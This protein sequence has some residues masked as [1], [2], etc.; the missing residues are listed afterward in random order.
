MALSDDLPEYHFN[1]GATK[2]DSNNAYWLS[3]FADSVYLDKEEN[4]EILRDLG[5]ETLAWHSSG[6]TQALVASN[7]ETIIIAFR[8]TEPTDFNDIAAD[9]KAAQIDW[10][11]GKV[12]TGFL[13]AIDEV[14]KLVIGSVAE[15]RNNEQT[16]WVTGHSLGGAL[17]VL[18]ATDLKEN[19]I[20]VNGVYT[21]GQPRLGN[22]VFCELYNKMLGTK[23]FRFANVDDIVPDLP[24]KS[25]K[26]GDAELSY[27]DVGTPIWVTGDS[28][29]AQQ[30]IPADSAIN[31]ALSAAKAPGAHSSLGYRDTL[32]AKLNF[33]PFTAS[34]KEIQEATI[35]SVDDL[36]EETL[37]LLKGAGIDV[38]ELA[39]AAQNTKEAVTD[40]V[41]KASKW[42]KNLFGK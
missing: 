41:D 19:D 9:L 40:A 10:L 20:D 15:Q 39:E 22:H 24:P 6:G 12:H 35:S 5:L 32:L 14:D 27:H 23:T 36:D 1:S 37:E 29:L 28:E 42:T 18:C 3:F 11:G 7:A 16:V 21:F 13:G 26:L 30:Y 25:L 4:E 31:K 34:V 8:G 17:A 2:Y 38:L 33:D